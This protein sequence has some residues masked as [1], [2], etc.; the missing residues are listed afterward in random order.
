MKAEAVGKK[1]WFEEY[2]CGCVSETVTRKSFLR[3]YCGIHGSDRRHVYRDLGEAAI[4][5]TGK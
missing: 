1:G 4:E 2:S 3:G 5:E